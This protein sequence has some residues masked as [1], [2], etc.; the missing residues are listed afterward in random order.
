MVV[1][2]GLVILDDIFVLT[3]DLKRTY[4]YLGCIA[5]QAG[6]NFFFSVFITLYATPQEMGGYFYFQ[7]PTI[8]GYVLP[9]ILV[10]AAWLSSVGL[11]IISLRP[12][13]LF[14]S[15]VPVKHLWK[16]N[17]K[18]ALSGAISVSKHQTLT[19]FGSPR[20]PPIK[21]SASLNRFMSHLF[22]RR[23]RPAETRLYAFARNM[24][25]V[26]AMVALIFRTVTALLHA[27]NEIETRV[28]SE[29]CTKRASEIHSIGI[30]MER[31]TNDSTWK[32][33]PAGGAD[34]TVSASWS[35]QVG[36]NYKSYGE[37]NC[38]VQWSRNM[39]TSAASEHRSHTLELYTCNHTWADKPG[40]Y[41]R[42]N[43][44]GWLIPSWSQMFVY[45][46]TVRPETRTSNGGIMDNQM[47]YIWLL[48]SNE[49]AS[50]L[51]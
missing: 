6:I 14:R 42:F 13:F 37:A 34:I 18:D 36:R 41:N 1:F 8:L 48:N 16:V 40:N 38:T 29:D 33:L 23:V 12:I 32:D 51:S 25:A 30:L 4:T 24:F 35:D 43:K 22:F 28:T 17:T 49:L 2:W 11:L 3:I 9:A 27:Q 31:L 44:G 39:T 7:T 15:L 46:I 26:V 21:T 10:V 5:A 45:Q 47:P 19:L 50:N 20:D